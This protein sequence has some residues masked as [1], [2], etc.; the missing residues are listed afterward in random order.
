M[1]GFLVWICSKNEYSLSESG[2]IVLIEECVI[3]FPVKR[4]IYNP[5]FLKIK[6]N[7]LGEF[8]FFL[9]NFLHSV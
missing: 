8:H 9:D 2:T 7:D 5:H 6:W 1:G 3:D 4:R